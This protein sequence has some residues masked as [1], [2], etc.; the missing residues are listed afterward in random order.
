MVFGHV[1]RLDRWPDH[2]LT[3]GIAVCMAIITVLSASDG[4][5]GWDFY[6]A[7]FVTVAVVVIGVREKRRAPA[8]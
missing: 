6:A 1:K 3:F 8:G 2:K 4:Q 5:L 7:L